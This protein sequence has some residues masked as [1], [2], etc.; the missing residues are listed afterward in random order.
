[1]E[2]TVHHYVERVVCMFRKRMDGII[3][4]IGISLVLLLSACSN[5]NWEKSP[6]EETELNTLTDVTMEVKEK[7]YPTNTPG[8]DLLFKN[9]TDE[10][11]YYG[12]AFSV[13]K[14]EREEW[15]VVPFKGDIS[16]IEIAIILQPHSKNEE[17]VSFEL[18]EDHLEA[19]TYRIVKEVSGKP[20]AAEFELVKE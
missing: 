3:F 20:V 10:E 14:L 15:R 4:G 2:E 17:N 13:E 1:M 12:V 7:S 18:L 19:G 8:V 6:Y 11:Y 9:E 5:S 16:W